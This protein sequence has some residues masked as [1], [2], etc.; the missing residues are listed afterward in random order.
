MELVG[1]HTFVFSCREVGH[2]INYI[3]SVTHY[4]NNTYL[5][6]TLD[7]ENI[8]YAEIILRYDSHNDEKVF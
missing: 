3:Y 5:K 1:G 7:L 4:Y 2:L 6:I 8:I